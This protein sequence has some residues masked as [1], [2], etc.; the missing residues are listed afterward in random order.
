MAFDTLLGFKNCDALFTCAKTKPFLRQRSLF[1]NEPWPRMNP[2]VNF[3]QG[4]GSCIPTC[5]HSWSAVCCPGNPGAG[6]YR[7]QHPSAGV[8]A[9]LRSAF[10]PPPGCFVPPTPVPRNFGPYTSLPIMHPKRRR[11]FLILSLRPLIVGRGREIWIE[12]EFGRIFLWSYVFWAIWSGWARQMARDYFFGKS[13]A[14]LSG[15][16]HYSS[17]VIS[18]NYTH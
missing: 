6:S 9:C 11:G 1:P 7:C 10:P 8:L 18:F 2:L 4:A 13:K 14:M 3:A 12:E 16:G 15:P 5:A 17:Q